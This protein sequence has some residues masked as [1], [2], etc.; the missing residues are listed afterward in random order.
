M[1]DAQHYR[2]KEEVA[3]Y[4]KRDPIG[5]V[6]KVI[7]DKKYATEAELKEIEDRVKELVNECVQY[8]DESPFPD[9]SN[10]YKNVYIQEDYPFIKTH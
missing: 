4:Q 5:I 8:A 1:S 6:H 3:E 9:A 10:L 7:Q 2:T